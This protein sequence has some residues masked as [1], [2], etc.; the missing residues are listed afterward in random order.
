MRAGIFIAAILQTA[1][2]VDAQV[3]AHSTDTPLVVPDGG[4]G[5]ADSTI[6]FPV[7]GIVEDLELEIAVTFGN[8]DQSG[9]FLQLIGPNQQPPPSGFL[10]LTSPH[11]GDLYLRVNNH[12]AESCNDVCAP[13]GCGS[14]GNPGHLPCFR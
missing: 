6:E 8:P 7:D 2:S 10:F 5:R 9:V 4:A 12:A 14:P 13:N 3:T 11:G 1:V